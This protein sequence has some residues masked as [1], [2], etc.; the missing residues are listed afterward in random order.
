MLASAKD[1]DAGGAKRADG[2]VWIMARDA[3]MGKP[4]KL[5][6]GDGDTVHGI[7]QMAQARSQDQTHS[8]R[9]AACQSADPIRDSL[10]VL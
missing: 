7:G 4:V 5:V 2:K 10:S 6:I 1:G 8:D 3:R 9:V